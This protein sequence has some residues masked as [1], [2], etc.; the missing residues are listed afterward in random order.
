MMARW[1]QCSPVMLHLFAN[2]TL[3]HEGRRGMLQTDGQERAHTYALG[4]AQNLEM[5]KAGDV[6]LSNLAAGSYQVGI[7]AAGFQDLTVAVSLTEGATQRVDAVVAGA[8]NPLDQPFRR[9]PSRTE[10][11]SRTRRTGRFNA[12]MPRPLSSLKT[13]GLAWTPFSGGTR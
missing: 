10:M 3:S 9:L 6:R 11:R 7:S 1:Q 5:G 8:E 12:P 2:G 13:A 4:L